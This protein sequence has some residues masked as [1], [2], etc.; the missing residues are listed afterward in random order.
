MTKKEIT[1][2][3][4]DQCLSIYALLEYP[5]VFAGAGCV[6]THWP[7]GDP[8]VI[9]YLKRKLPASGHHKIYFDFGTETLDAQYEPYQKRV[10]TIMR[11]TGYREGEN[12]MTRKF[13]GQEHSER[14]WKK[15]VHI[16]LGFF[17]GKG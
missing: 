14:A 10:D 16:P 3:A 11:A 13:D 5:D 8:A 2:K 15:R 9:D 4:R 17:L 7:I 6:S 12:W 1:L